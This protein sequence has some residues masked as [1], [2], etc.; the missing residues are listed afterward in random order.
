[1]VLLTVIELEIMKFMMEAVKPTGYVV[2]VQVKLSC[3]CPGPRCISQ[4][5]VSSA[6]PASRSNL[7]PVTPTL[8]IL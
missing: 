3:F 2:A 6:S 4:A 1:M 8:S 7:R 5:L